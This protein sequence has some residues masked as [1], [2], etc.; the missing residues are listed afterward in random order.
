MSTNNTVIE[1]INK[2]PKDLKAASSTLGRDEARFLVDLYYSMQDQRIGLKSQG[3]ALAATE[4]LHDTVAFFADQFATLE[5]QVKGA[6]DAYSA[7]D[8]LGQW[9]REQLGIG[10]VIA[11]GLLAHIDL[12]RA[13]TVGHIWRFAGLDP[14]V[15]WGKGERRPWNASLKVLCWKIG[16]SFV[17]LSGREDAFYGQVYKK[18]KAYEIERDLAVQVVPNGATIQEKDQTWGE[19]TKN[20]EILDCWKAG[21]TWYY[22]GNAKTC[23]QTLAQ[24]KF[25][26]VATKKKYESGHLPDGRLD[27]RARRYAAKLFLAHYHEMGYRLVLKKEPPLPYAIAQGHAHKID[28]PGM[29][30][31]LGKAA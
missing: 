18:R 6:L 4:E 26:D 16:E 23:A 5:K 2:L 30:S 3:R 22:G 14:S 21:D 31:A 19:L 7:G 11:A 17:K 28:P 8:V 1:I 10:P 27:A 13:P 29:D 20:G 12:D 15:T 9:A 25:K 24:K